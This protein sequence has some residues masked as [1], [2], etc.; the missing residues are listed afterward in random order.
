MNKYSG[1]SDGTIVGPAFASSA[2]GASPIG[3]GQG[4]LPVKFQSF[5]VKSNTKKQALLSWIVSD[6]E[7][8]AN[9]SIEKSNDGRTWKLMNKQPAKNTSQTQN[10]YADIDSFLLTGNN[11]YR[12]L[13]TGFNGEFFYSAIEML[14]ERNTKI[15]SVYPNPVSSQLH[16]N[17]DQAT[18]HAPFTIT[19]YS[20]NSVKAD[21]FRFETMPSKIALNISHLPKASYRISLTDNAG[22]KQDQTIIIY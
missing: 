12:I 9:Y 14:A 6:E 7:Q 19:I 10:S 2:T 20:M 15:F 16:L 17:I 8:I 13:A 4:I 3:F 21:Q 18:I 1:N 5:F 22:I 11:Y